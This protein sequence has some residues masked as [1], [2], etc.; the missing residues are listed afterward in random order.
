MRIFAELKPAVNPLQGFI[1]ELA[2]LPLCLW[3]ALGNLDFSHPL[4]HARLNATDSSP[5]DFAGAAFLIR[6]QAIDWPQPVEHARVFYMSRTV[7]HALELLGTAAENACQPGTGPTDRGPSPHNITGRH[8]HGADSVQTRRP[9][10]RSCS[11][12]LVWRTQGRYPA[13]CSIVSFASLQ[14]TQCCLGGMNTGSWQG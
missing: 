5:I 11:T 13:P 7:I 10:C 3:N 1:R 8:A 9:L 12:M 6:D 4:L 14:T 2:G